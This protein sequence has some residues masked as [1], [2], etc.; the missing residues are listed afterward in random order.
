MKTG[1]TVRDGQGH[2]YQLGQLLGRGLWGKTYVVRREGDDSL[3]VLKCPLG[4]GDFRGDVPDAIYAI[5]REAVLETARLYE[6]GQ[7]LFL[8]KLEDRI[9]MPDGAPAI[10]MPRFA[11]SLERRIVEGMPVG[12]LLEVL[13]AVA[14]HLRQLQATPGSWGLHGN[15]KPTNVLFNERGDV[16]LTDLATPAVR[17]ALPRLAAVAGGAPYL[18]PEVVDAIGEP[19]W[20]AGVDTYGLATILWRGIQGGEGPMDWP[21]GGLDKKAQIALKDHLLERMKLEDSN[22]RFHGR[23]AER[24]AVLLS[25]ALSRETA[26]SPPFRFPRL[27]ELQTR[28]EEVA[29]LVRPSVTSVGKVMLDRP[30][31]KPWFTTDEDVAYSITVGCSNGVEGHEEI[32]VGIAVF[33]LDRDERLK[34]LD[35]GYTVDR[36]PSGRYKFSFRIGGLGPGRF[37]ARVAFAIRDS[38]NPP[39]T[40]EAEFNVRAAPGWVPRASHEPVPSPLKMRPEND[41]VTVKTPAPTSLPPEEPVPTHGA[42]ALPAPAHLGPPAPPSPTYR[43]ASLLP[44]D[45]SRPPSWRDDTGF[46]APS[47]TAVPIPETPAPAIQL[48]AG[49]KAVQPPTASPPQRLTSAPARAA[50]EAA[51]APLPAPI[52]PSLPPPE[53][54]R[55]AAAPPSPAVAAPPVRATPVVPEEEPRRV[56]PAFEPTW[57]AR[58]WAHEPLPSAPLRDLEA[59]AEEGLPEPEEE[60]AGPSFLSRVTDQLRNDP[61]IAVMAG[62]GLVIVVL[63]VVFLALRS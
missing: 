42:A 56:E 24:A 13:L 23:L 50:E 17:R 51:H 36:H 11:E 28:L 27:D 39:A 60:P 41:T 62:L 26:P 9:A 16:F 34:D 45:P 12:Q 3:H 18:P 59:E 38:G 58:D 48:P 14:K 46:G 40:V 32:G 33:D 61:Y 63:F 57:K 55:A 1:D 35:L 20:N 30:A 4:P 2:S 37:R 52:P 44:P 49:Q 8:P 53:P 54:P 47:I 22:P 29:A 25:R 43:P 10:V 21:R 5:S 6:Q 15:L 19:A 31:S 7:H